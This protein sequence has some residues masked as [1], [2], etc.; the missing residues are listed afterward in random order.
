MGMDVV[1]GLALGL[2]GGVVLVASEWW[3]EWH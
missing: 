2:V 3:L 1:V